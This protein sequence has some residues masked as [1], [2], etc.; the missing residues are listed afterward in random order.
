MEGLGVG[1]ELG[2]ELRADPVGVAERG[3]AG[4]TQAGHEAVVGARVGDV[5]R[6]R[7]VGLTAGVEV[8]GAGG[9]HVV[10]PGGRQRGVA[11]RPARRISRGDTVPIRDGI[12]HIL[13][14]RTAAG[15]QRRDPP[16]RDAF[17]HA[18]EGRPSGRHDLANFGRF[19]VDD[20]SRQRC[21]TIG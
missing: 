20:G 4:E 6:D 1:G 10:L 3:V 16:P 8:A 18:R 19:D 7:A 21:R 11:V 13:G 15:E 5:A 14:G 9:G 17:G 2:G 12:E